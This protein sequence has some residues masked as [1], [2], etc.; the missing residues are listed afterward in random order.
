[1]MA[2]WPAGECLESDASCA[3]P[4]TTKFY[5]GGTVDHYCD[6]CLT[7]NHGVNT[8]LTDK[9]IRLNI[10]MSGSY[11]NPDVSEGSTKNALGNNDWVWWYRGGHWNCM[12]GGSEGRRCACTAGC[13]ESSCDMT[14]GN[15]FHGACRCAMYQDPTQTYC[16]NS[17]LNCE[18]CPAGTYRANCGCTDTTRVGVLPGEP[19]SNT[20]RKWRCRAG[21]C[22]PNP[23]DYYTPGP[24]IYP[25]PCPDGY[26]TLGRTGST[27]CTACW[28]PNVSKQYMHSILYMRACYGCL[29]YVRVLAPRAY[30][31]FLVVTWIGGDDSMA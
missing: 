14:E 19:A 5:E 22:L 11:C 17:K 27:N 23:V 25:F 10:T 7:S 13:Y 15:A 18:V 31:C 21:T 1:M 16:F 24:S 9:N 30:A 12:V 8:S 3:D 28:G 2:Q 4:T 26:S 20:N 29:V 6:G